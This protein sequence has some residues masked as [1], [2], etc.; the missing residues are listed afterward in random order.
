M[1]WKKIIGWILGILFGLIVL[2][3]AAGYFVMR[4]H[5]FQQYV[6]AKVEQTAAEA[7][8]GKVELQGFDF[9]PSTLTADAYGLVIHGTEPAGQAPLLSLDK[10]TLR[11]KILSVLHKDVNLREIIVQHPVVHF[12]VA[13]DGR[14]NLP[15]PNAPKDKSS[16]TDV[17]QLAIG[18]VLLT[19][20]Q[21]Y[22]NDQQTPLNADVYDL[23]AEIK[24]DPL[25]TQ[26][27]GS[28]SYNNGKLQY[29]NYTSLTHD[30]HAQFS[31]NRDKATLDGLDLRVGA[32]RIALKATVTN[33]SAPH[34][35][36]T[37]SALVHTEDFA[38]MLKSA[39]ASANGDV[40]LSG[41]LQYQSVEGQPALKAVTI[42]GDV[43]SRELRVATPEARVAMG[44]L[45]GQYQLINGNAE[46]TAKIA[47]LL[48][49]RVTTAVSIQRLDTTPA[50][51]VR[52]NFDGIS[53]AAAKSAV[54]SLSSNNFP[55]TGTANG[56]ADASWVG[57]IAK[58]QAK[59]DVGVRAAIH[60]PSGTNPI[61]LDAA[62]HGLYDGRTSRITLNNTALRTPSATVLVNGTVSERGNNLRLAANT[63]DVH[64]LILLASAFQTAG[65]KPPP[66]VSGPATLSALVTGTSANPNISAQLAA[67]NLQVEGTRWSTVRLN[68][69]ANPSQA[70][71][72][73]GILTNARRGEIHFSGAVGLRKW[74]YT[75]ESPIT[76][77]A[78]I[79]QIPVSE[80]QQLAN[81]NYPVS[82]VLTAD[83]ALHGTELDP[84]GHGSVQLLNASAYD[85]PIQNLSA[86]FQAANETVNS[87]LNIKTPAGN[88][89]GTLDFTPRT[90]AY[91]VQFDAPAVALQKLQAVQAKNIPVQGTLSAT[92][93]GTGTL[94]DPNLQATVQIPQLQL[95]QTAMTGVRADLSV[96]NHKAGFTLGSDVAQDTIRAR[97]SV[98]LNGDYYTNAAIDTTRIPLDPLLAAYVSGLPEGA[99]SNLELHATVKGPLKNK[100]QL[101]VHL[102]IPTFD[103]QY[104]Q[105]RIANNGPIRMDYLNAIV[106]IQPS[107]LQ[108]TDSSLHIEGRIPPTEHAGHRRDCK[109]QR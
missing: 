17:F 36:G 61:P 6:I 62:V 16:N 96:A 21:I 51:K 106:T 75:P 69:Q 64:D 10:L 50:G 55:V 89:N 65:N 18:H 100:D 1:R 20:G 99:S 48:N 5:W 59:A 29:A 26:Y 77:N 27:N 103:A 8:G 95:K 37:Y 105:I 67:D 34:V 68:A 12:M 46:A 4:S 80:L 70:Q 49:G 47:N 90:K 109:G 11:L 25:A 42:H 7:T 82:G 43:S 92:A 86:K 83:L 60:P 22:Y 78:T 39:S 71:V 73:N 9:H 2:I 104:Q 57:D 32:S 54:R 33:Y 81:V 30:L 108:G 52:L 31:A 87:Q 63:R 101:E 97:G 93:S 14:N 41:T 3:F 23:G 98:D 15:S 13:K 19:D 38:P 44:G 107:E 53:I 84:V 40:A 28:V 35:D 45:S 72:Q 88:A 74:S 94:D 85:Q 58:M 102:T 24:F 91:R 76:A 79:R 66:N 56:V